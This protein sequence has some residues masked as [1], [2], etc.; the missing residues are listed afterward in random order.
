MN[1]E[2]IYYWT[3]AFIEELAWA[4]K[5]GNFR[6]EARQHTVIN[7]RKGLSRFVPN[8]IMPLRDSYSTFIFEKPFFVFLTFSL[9]CVHNDTMTY[10]SSQ[11]CSIFSFK[12]P[13]YVWKIIMLFWNCYTKHHIHKSVLKIW[14]W[15]TGKKL[16][17]LSLTWLEDDSN[18]KKM[19]KKLPILTSQLY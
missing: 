19:S 4:E 15:K 13:K 14:I 3:K 6:V 2:C 9:D 8:A 7:D 1:R 10:K 12:C 18:L 17:V 16:L 5:N 11:L